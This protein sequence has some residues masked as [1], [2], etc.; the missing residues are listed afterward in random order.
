MIQING[1]HLKK[2]S[3]RYTKSKVYLWVF[4]W[5]KYPSDTDAVAP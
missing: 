1:V 4:I 5:N 2:Y 3:I